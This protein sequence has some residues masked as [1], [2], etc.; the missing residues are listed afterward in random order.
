MIIDILDEPSPTHSSSVIQSNEFQTQT[1]NILPSD[2]I[3][4]SPSKQKKEDNLSD[5]PTTPIK[6]TTTINGA[7]TSHIPIMSSS[8]SSS[9][10]LSVSTPSSGEHATKKQVLLSSTQVPRRASMS[11]PGAPITLI[12]NKVTFFF[13]NTF[14]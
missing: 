10:S 14:Q 1:N 8:S 13:I 12:L 3:I 4:S 7:V 11:A 2:V 6:T 9:S 5:I